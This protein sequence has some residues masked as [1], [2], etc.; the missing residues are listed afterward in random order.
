MTAS[1]SAPPGIFIS[2]RRSDAAA[3][4]GWLFDRLA[5]HYGRD[6]IFKDVDSIQLGDDFA[7]AIS[8]A[9]AS[10]QVLLALIGDRWL[11]ISGKAGRRLDNPRDFVR[12]EIEAALSRNIRVIPVLIDGA[13]M[14][15]ADQLPASMAGLRARQALELSTNRFDSDFSRLLK[16]LDKTLSTP[17]AVRPRTVTP[18][19]PVSV[20]LE[21]SERIRRLQELRAT[22]PSIGPATGAP[23]P[24]TPVTG[25]AAFRVQ[26]RCI[27]VHP[28]GDLAFFMAWPQLR[29]YTSVSLPPGA[30]PITVPLSS[31]VIPGPP[32]LVGIWNP[33]NFSP[34]SW[35][36]LTDTKGIVAGRLA[37]N[38]EGFGTVYARWA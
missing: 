26:E 38:V 9:V 28:Q 33:P 6:Q 10:C 16:V 30:W 17:Q 4:A 36:Q 24:G 23:S 8:D 34:G 3:Y 12:L 1:A 19:Q 7:A 32:E 14:P 13:T 11:T 20:P 27:Y 25:T 21:S 5:G 29:I 31:L 18:G 37:V 22:L 2:Y 15:D 35:T